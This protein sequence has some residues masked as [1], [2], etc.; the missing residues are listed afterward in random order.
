MMKAVYPG[1]FD[2]VTFGHLDI[3]QRA[4]KVVDELIIG[5]IVNKAKKSPLFTLEERVSMLKEATKEYPNVTVKMFDGMTID[6][7]RENGARLIIRGLRAVTDFESEM[8][9]AQTN[10]S[11]DSNIDTMFFT[12]S[13]E[14]SF[15]SSTVVKE[16]ASYGRDTSKFVPEVV[17]KAFREKFQMD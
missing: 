9:I 10:H 3:I 15:L 7:A 14:Y 11:L 17:Q 16:V 12:T 8:Q 2:P 1:S 5:V 13:L 4:A 6:F